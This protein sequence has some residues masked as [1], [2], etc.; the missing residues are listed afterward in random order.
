M[1]DDDAEEIVIDDG[2]EDTTGPMSPHVPRG[3]AT[4]VMKTEEQ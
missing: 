1:I 4:G 3:C 2:P